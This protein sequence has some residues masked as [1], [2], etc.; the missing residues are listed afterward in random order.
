MQSIVSPWQLPG[1]LSSRLLPSSMPGCCASCCPPAAATAVP[2]AAGCITMSYW[3]SRPLLLP[4]SRLPPSGATA[5]NRS[6]GTPD[7]T[8]QPRRL[9]N[10]A[11]MLGS[12]GAVR[13]SQMFTAACPT[14]PVGPL[15]MQLASVCML[16]RQVSVGTSHSRRLPSLERERSRR[17]A[18]APAAA[19]SA[20]SR[21][22]PCSRWVTRP[23][24][25]LITAATAAAGG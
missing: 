11:V 21:V 24:T 14:P 6:G 13:S 10:S 3:C 19:S 1:H 12:A 20:T 4:T 5:C 23:S 15:T 18:P 7:Q 2:A 17:G 8:L 9:C 16:D 22:W 25:T